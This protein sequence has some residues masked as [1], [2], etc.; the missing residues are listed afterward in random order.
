MGGL[1]NKRLGHALLT[2]SLVPLPYT[3]GK[4]LGYANT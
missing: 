4:A 2:C 1:V 3:Y